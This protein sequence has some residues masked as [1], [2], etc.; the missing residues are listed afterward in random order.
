LHG[1]E[2]SNAHGWISQYNNGSLYRT[3]WTD[4]PTVKELHKSYDRAYAIA[5]KHET[6]KADASG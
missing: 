6:G 2:L 1:L 3:V 5:F 4:E